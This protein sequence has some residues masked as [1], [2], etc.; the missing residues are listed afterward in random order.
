[1][2]GFSAN[3]SFRPSWNNL[4]D[5]PSNLTSILYNASVSPQEVIVE[6]VLQSQHKS[7]AGWSGMSSAGVSNISIDPIFAHSLKLADKQSIIVNVK[8]RNPKTSTV[9]LEPETASDWELVELHASYIEAKLIEQSRCVAVD[10]VLVVYPTKTSSVRLLVKDIRIP[11]SSYALIDPFAEINIAP[12]VREKKT[13]ASAQSVKSTKS[14][15]SIPSE[16]AHGPSILKRG[17]A[18][19]HEI[20][21]EEPQATENDGYEVYARMDELA[22][23]FERS[24]YASVSIVPGPNAKQNVAPTN[25]NADEE[26]TK[27]KLS[28]VTENKNIIAKLVFTNCVPSNT[29]GLSRKLAVSLNV[30]SLVGFKV[31]LRVA[32]KSLSRR[33]AT[34]LVHPYI[35][36]SKKNDLLKLNALAS[37]NQHEKINQM[38]SEYLFNSK[39][40]IT[41]YPITNFTK[42]P[43]IPDVLPYGGILS[44]ARK[45]DPNAWIDPDRKS[46]WSAKIE[47]DED[48][49]RSASFVESPNAIT[50][51]EPIH[52]LEQM[53]E[54]ITEHLSTFR[55]S[56]ILVHGASGSGKSLL[57]KWIAKRVSA[58]C[59]MFIKYVACETIMNETFDQLSARITK[60]IQEAAWHE[61]SLLVLDNLD[62]I[63][64]AEAENTDSTSS[65]QTTEFF[66]SSL[67]KVM[68]QNNTNV[69]LLIS[70]IA[71]ESF[72][73]LL[74]L[75]HLIEGYHHLSPPGKAARRAILEDCLVNKLGCQ[76]QMDVMDI[77]LESEGYLPNDL[78]VISDRIFYESVFASQGLSNEANIITKNHVEKAFSGFQPSGLRGVKLQKSSTSWADIGGLS[79]AKKVLLETLEWPTK[80]APIFANCPLRLRSGILLYGYPGCGKTLL[81]SAISGQ[82][83][84]NFISIKGPE[85]LNKYIG[86]SEQSVRELFERA[87]AAKPCIL[88][89][90][91]F[92]SIAPKRGHDSTGVTDRVVNQLLTQMDGAEGLD[93]VY[94]LAATSRPDLID[95]ALLRPG[96]LDKSIICDMPS[97][98]DR[99]D[100]LKCVSASMQLQEDVD[101]EF[102]ASKTAGF[103]GADM[104]G[105]GYNAYLK[106]V[107]E[108]LMEQET[109]VS[110]EGNSLNNV[111]DFFQISSEQL[112]S[113]KVRPAEKLKLLQKIENLFNLK[114]IGDK[115]VKTKT[116]AQQT[117]LIK[118]EH[119]LESLKETKPSI[120]ASEKAKLDHIYTQFL[121]G[122]DGKMPDGSA[123]NEIGGRTT[124]M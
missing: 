12:K 55:N 24:P 9:F 80:Y 119:F 1:M 115:T 67:S 57:L 89:F 110:E 13:S 120:S 39:D 83:G 34:F 124:L 16:G 40:P 19:P 104:Q 38:V 117:V 96:R 2:D 69:S 20:F 106:A 118:Q 82:C 6:L 72:N 122:R 78:K 37:K 92:D 71:R 116:K 113:N 100:I 90:D 73:K 84:L 25:E 53:L 79:E 112:K 4:V 87:Q 60:Y 102:V 21:Q 85:I 81:A 10:Q 27:E 94:V 76:I 33:P 114:N 97:L 105:L 18:L 74:F 64:P 15:K 44:F 46:K 88:F 61:P 121:T 28:P 43:A 62:K 31:V 35:I 99:I 56:G 77:V 63:L 51:L 5:L 41:K 54:D 75:S 8:I 52:G 59:G 29:V 17:I 65:N 66:I 45:R 70:G 50:D 98:Q 91:E 48:V 111:Y 101:L 107:H 32:G 30:D 47:V 11:D 49:L 36:Q 22:H 86:A 123:S 14:S 23:A 58:T 103:S 3:I 42:I 68:A 7:Y 93:G 108:T 26:K 95:S 109:N